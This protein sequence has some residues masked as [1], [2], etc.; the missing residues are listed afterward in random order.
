MKFA[1]KKKMGRNGRPRNLRV[2]DPDEQ[3]D[4]HAPRRSH[5]RSTPEAGA[6]AIVAVPVPAAVVR[7]HLSGAVG[8]NVTKIAR[9]V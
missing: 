8:P 3:F 4:G 9:A 5:T 2:D 7:A 1:T 6:Y